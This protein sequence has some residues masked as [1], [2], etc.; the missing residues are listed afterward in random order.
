MCLQQN[1]QRKA[2]RTIVLGVSEERISEL[3]LSLR[4]WRVSSEVGDRSAWTGC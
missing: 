2:D 1:G 4:R 3:I